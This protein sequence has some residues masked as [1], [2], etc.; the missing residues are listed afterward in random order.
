VVAE[1][2]TAAAQFAAA[3]QVLAEAHT[4]LD[5]V[6]EQERRMRREFE[7]GQTDRLALIRAELTTLEARQAR[8]V[9]RA[10]AWRRRFALDDATQLPLDAPPPA[11]DTGS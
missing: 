5:A 7:L 8:E 11:A 10:E 1:V 9:L 6:T 3:M 4:I 2:Q